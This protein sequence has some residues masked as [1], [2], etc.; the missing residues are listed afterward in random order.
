MPEVN[1]PQ[2]VPAID[3]GVMAETARPGRLQEESLHPPVEQCFVEEES[4]VAVINLQANQGSNQKTDQ[5]PN[6]GS[7][8]PAIEKPKVGSFFADNTPDTAGMNKRR[9]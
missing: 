4:S 3:H 7:M 8:L 9:F 5:G 2:C 6:A 1:H